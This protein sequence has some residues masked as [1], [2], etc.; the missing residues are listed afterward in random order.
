MQTKDILQTVKCIQCE[1]ILQSPVFLPC[2]ISICQKHITEQ[3]S[4]VFYCQTCHNDHI[5]PD[6]G[7]APN[8]AV[9]FLIDFNLVDY[10]KAKN[11]CHSLKSS[12]DELSSIK[13]DPHAHIERVLGELKHE[14]RSKRDALIVEIKTKSDKMINEL[15]IYTNEC[16][17]SLDNDLITN[18]FANVEDNIAR[19]RVKLEQWLNEL[20]SLQETSQANWKSILEKCEV[21]KNNLTAFAQ[22]MNGHL[23]RE[24]LDEYKMKSDFLKYFKPENNQR[25]FFDS[26]FYSESK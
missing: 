16:N 26:P 14:I 11:A 9:I 5:V 20:P 10:K 21:E 8:N 7:F 22:K 18:M 4:N 25:F 1:C 6:T 17:S 23:F 2:G 24:K 3:N 15:E 19:N 12:I 13:I